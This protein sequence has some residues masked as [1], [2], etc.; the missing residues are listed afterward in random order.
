[1]ST[2]KTAEEIAQRV[3]RLR[4][5]VAYYDE[6]EADV[7]CLLDA[8]DAQKQEAERLRATVTYIAAWKLYDEDQRQKTDDMA[9]AYETA[10]TLCR[11]AIAPQPTEAQEET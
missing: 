9:G 1:M 11:A 8:H 5:S 6:L 10:I 3:E 4:N 7:V 2:Q